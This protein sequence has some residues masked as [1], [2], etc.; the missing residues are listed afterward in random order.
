MPRIELTFA[1]LDPSVTP[2]M[3]AAQFPMA[4]ARKLTAAQ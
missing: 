2:E 1:P 3:I 4:R